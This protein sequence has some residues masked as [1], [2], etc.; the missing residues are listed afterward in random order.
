MPWRMG[1]NG[2][3]FPNSLSLLPLASCKAWF[4][5]PLRCRR[6][7]FCFPLWSLD[8]LDMSPSEV[9]SVS[10]LPGTKISCKKNAGISVFSY[11]RRNHISIF[12][13]VIYIACAVIVFSYI[14][15]D[16]LDLDG[17]NFPLPLSPVKS[18]AIVSDVQKDIKRSYLSGLTELWEPL[19]ALPVD[20]Q[21]DLVPPDPAKKPGPSG[22][23]S[24]RGRGY[25]VALPRS[26]IEDSSP[27]A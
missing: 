23:D 1:K 13:R 12:R 6:P 19:S 14:F 10:L 18:S 22:L 21:T 3:P 5:P 27:S 20:G 25:R 2:N 4:G 8:L 7:R 15:F 26:S 16:V 9:L 24:S 11:F 17:S